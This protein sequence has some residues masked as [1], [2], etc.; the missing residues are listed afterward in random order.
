MRHYLVTIFLVLSMI[1]LQLPVSAAETALDRAQLGETAAEVPADEGTDIESAEAA[2][3]TETDPEEAGA[4]ETEE[5]QDYDGDPEVSPEQEESLAEQEPSKTETDVIEED[6]TEGGSEAAG[7][8][9]EAA[10]VPAGD[11]DDEMPEAYEAEG[12]VVTEQKEAKDAASDRKS[13][14][15]LF[16]SR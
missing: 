6:A 16:R 12:T 2:G 1:S 4:G 5:T 9:E 8:E 14:L 7:N 10:E 3:A 13:T 11:G 15:L